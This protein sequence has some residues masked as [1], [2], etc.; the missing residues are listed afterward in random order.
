MTDLQLQILLLNIVARLEAAIIEADL[1]LENVPRHKGQRYIGK[2]RLPGLAALSKK[3]PDDWEETEE[4]PV[5]LTE[6][7]EVVGDIRSQADALSVI[8]AECVSDT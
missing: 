4:S 2:A 3:N 8:F 5:A 6:L 7:I 1:S